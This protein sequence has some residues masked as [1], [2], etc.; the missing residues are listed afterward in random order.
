[1]SAPPDSTTNNQ[2]K[3]SGEDIVKEGIV[4]DD[5][6]VNDIR[7]HI[8]QL[9]LENAVTYNGQT[10]N[11]KILGK[12]LG[13]RQ[14]LRGSVPMV[15]DVVSDV[16]SQVNDMS[17]QDQQK[18]LEEITGS[19]SI[20][21][22]KHKQKDKDTQG[23]GD[24]NN[25]IPGAWLPPLEDVEYGKVITRF[26]P[27]P[28]GYPH[29][30]HAKAVIIN[31]D[32][33]TRY[34]GKCILRIDDTNPD[35]ERKEYIAGINVGLEWLGLEF[36]QE[37]I[38]YTSDDMDTLYQKGEELIRNGRAYV[39]TCKKDDISNGRRDRIECKCRKKDDIDEHYK[40][41]GKMHA[42]KIK[43]GEAVVRFR[44]NMQA[45][46]AVMRDP[47]LFR[48]TSTPH[49]R[50]GSKYRVW[51]S[52]DMSVAIEDSIHGITHA[53]RSKE[54]ESRAEL[55]NDILDVL[56]MRKPKQHYFARLAFDGMP[57]SKR[58]IKPL[59]EDGRILGYDDPRIPTLGGLK[60]RGIKP[61]AVRKFIESLGLT[62]ADTIAPFETL[63]SINRHLIDSAS[64][65]LFM[66]R[67]PRRIIIRN[68]DGNQ[69]VKKT[70]TMPS[71][72]LYEKMGMRSVPASGDIYIPGTDFEK[73]Q[74]GSII[75]LLGLGYVRIA[76]I[77]KSKDNNH[78][79]N[80]Y[81]RYASNEHD[82]YATMT[83][84]AYADH[85]T[86]TNNTFDAQEV[87]EFYEKIGMQEQE[88]QQHTEPYSE[89]RGN[90]STY[91][92]NDSNS[93]TNE[94][95]SKKE[96]KEDVKTQWVSQDTAVRIRL[97]IPKKP[98]DKNDN[99]DENSLEEIEVYTEPHFESIKEGEEIQFVRFGYCIKDTGRRVIFTHD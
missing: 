59:M 93:H 33:A 5:D 12:I 39:C 61:E 25:N 76:D 17:L 75:K 88:Q 52:Y 69:I 92:N 50:Q 63:E 27:E 90:S 86:G 70:V 21:M 30:G 6:N 77:S 91:N 29:I 16:V 49:Y 98:F 78:K 62:K 37:N 4:K 53:F 66:V 46:N 99:F 73:L 44:G 35:A 1:M 19:S 22:N 43:S 67:D 97:A 26:P 51:P 31:A 32:Y 54:F 65:R 34:G 42:G 94:K 41:W 79:T 2:K 13:A 48:I 64:T 85:I 89:K 15:S 84:S 36:K 9:A 7:Q 71:H 95:K 60:R 18:R 3:N 56:N 80:R 23:G 45:D 74:V 81:R 83:I 55:I 24:N 58:L 72:P 40:K 14:D 28:N 57:T 68:T 87:S 82:D 38:I 47:I 10:D 8:L 96:I 20:A 11:K